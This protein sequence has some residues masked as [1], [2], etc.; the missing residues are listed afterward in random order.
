[1]AHRSRL[2]ADAAMAATA[3]R[4]KRSRADLTGTA[5]PG[6]NSGS[7]ARGSRGG[8][9]SQDNTHTDESLDGFNIQGQNDKRAIVTLMTAVTQL[10]QHGRQHRATIFTAVEMAVESPIAQANYSE[11]DH[12]VDCAQRGEIPKEH[13]PDLYTFPVMID[14]LTKLEVGQR[15]KVAL[16]AYAEALY[17]EGSEEEI[18]LLLMEKMHGPRKC[19]LMVDLRSCRERKAILNA[20]QQLEGY[21]VRQRTAPRGWMETSSVRW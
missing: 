4:A 6:H 19:R 7:A 16:T 10:Q 15:S 9:R 13:P 2:P 20:L 21:T 3:E 5:G 18:L 8:R 17:Q 11:Q 1:M 14:Q 12:Y